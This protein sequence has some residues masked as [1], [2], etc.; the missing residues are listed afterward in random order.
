[1]FILQIMSKS[2]LGFFFSF[3]ESF[4]TIPWR[5]LEIIEN[6]ENGILKSVS[7]AIENFGFRV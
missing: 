6:S 5:T 7:S 2:K 3:S 4:G 1:M